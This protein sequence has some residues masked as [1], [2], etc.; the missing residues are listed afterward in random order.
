MYSG[1]TAF[2]CPTVRRK[3]ESEVGFSPAALRTIFLNRLSVP[4]VRDRLPGC[5]QELLRVRTAASPPRSLWI[6]NLVFMNVAV[7]VIRADTIG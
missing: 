2:L 6:R 1:A 5:Y 7:N 4:L 3:L